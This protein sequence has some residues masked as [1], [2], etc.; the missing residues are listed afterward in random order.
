MYEIYEKFY[1]IVVYSLHYIF[2]YLPYL[3][4]GFEI[5]C[6][7]FMGAQNAH[8]TPKCKPGRKV[9]DNAFLFRIETFCA[10]WASYEIGDVFVLALPKTTL[11]SPSRM[12]TINTGFLH[13]TNKYILTSPEPTQCSLS[14]Y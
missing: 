2:R 3:S 13:S 8:K 14:V 9:L 7:G 5:V 1:L 4:H 10:K 6:S 12:L 11:A